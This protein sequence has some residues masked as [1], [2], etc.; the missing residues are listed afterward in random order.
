MVTPLGP[1]VMTDFLGSQARGRALLSDLLMMCKGLR[2]SLTVMEGYLLG[3]CVLF[4]QRI[5]GVWEAG[6]G[7]DKGD[8]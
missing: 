1:A 8:R 2:P 4:I 3:S 5:V 6:Q 7:G